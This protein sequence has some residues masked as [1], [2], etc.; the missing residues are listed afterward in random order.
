MTAPPISRMQASLHVDKAVC[1]VRKSSA[2]IEHARM[3]LS[4]RCDTAKVGDAALFYLLAQA[5]GKPSA[6]DWLV[7]QINEIDG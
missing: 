1:A 2:H 4:G 7:E 6:L 3:A 5:A